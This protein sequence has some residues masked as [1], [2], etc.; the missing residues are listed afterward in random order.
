[1]T[2]DHRT[3]ATQTEASPLA[4]RLRE[5]GFVVNDHCERPTIERLGELHLH[6][7]E[8][9]A[10]AYCVACVK[11][12][13][14]LNEI[15]PNDPE[16]E[17]DSEV[18]IND[19]CLVCEHCGVIYSTQM[20]SDEMGVL[21]YLIVQRANLIEVLKVFDGVPAD[22]HAHV[23]IAHALDEQEEILKRNLQSIAVK[24]SKLAKGELPKRPSAKKK[25]VLK[26]VADADPDPD[27]TPPAA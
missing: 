5:V 19:L 8:A 17:G 10:T 23:A 21:C 9:C 15:V 7:H 22:D 12:L 27:S 16:C 3:S 24:R 13:C 2:Q 14:V 26:L 20:M 18:D 4:R 25:G 11:P 6:H 1:M